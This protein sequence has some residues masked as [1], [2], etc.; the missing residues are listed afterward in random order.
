[1][2]CVSNEIAYDRLMVYDTR[3]VPFPGGAGPDGGPRPKYPRSSWADVAESAGAD[4]KWV[5]A[6]GEAL[7]RILRRLNGSEF[8]VLLGQIYVLSPFVKV[9][10][11]CRSLISREFR[12]VIEGELTAAGVKREDLDAAVREF[13]KTHVGTVHTMQGKEADVVIFVLGTDPSPGKAAI[14]WASRTVNLLNVAV[15]RARRRFFVIGSYAE[16]SGAPNFSVLAKH[17]PRHQ[18][19]SGIR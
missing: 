18:W 1:M 10:G 13:L 8:G 14:D 2:F 16:W 3:E 5:P 12:A 7:E 15:S 19:R 4:E 17:L 11:R 6:Q 9:A